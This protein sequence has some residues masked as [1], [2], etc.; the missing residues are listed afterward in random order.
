MKIIR[1]VE[2]KTHGYSFVIVYERGI[3]YRCGLTFGCSPK[4]SHFYLC[5]D[6]GVFYLIDNNIPL[7]DL[8]CSYYIKVDFKD[9]NLSLFECSLLK[10][11]VINDPNK[12]KKWRK[13]WKSSIPDDIKISRKIF[14]FDEL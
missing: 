5:S 13:I 2:N 4:C 10:L 12:D 9:L 7:D 14:S 1:K 8:Y 3:L 11:S 6:K